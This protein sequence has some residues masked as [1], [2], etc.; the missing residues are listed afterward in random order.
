MT[1]HVDELRTDVSVDAATAAATPGESGGAESNRWRRV[2]EIRAIQ[3][4]LA[5]EAQRTSAEGYGD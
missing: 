5:R 4:R 3:E 1:I 2:D